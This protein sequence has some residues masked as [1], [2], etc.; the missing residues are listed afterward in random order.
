[1]RTLNTDRHEL[2]LKIYTVVVVAH[3][4]E[5]IAQAIQ[6]YVLDWPVQQARGILG[7]PFPGLVT[8]EWMHYG[9]AAIMLIGFLL[10]LPGFSG[11]SRVW[12]SAA[13]LLQIWHHFEH[14]I[15]LV[16]VMNGVNIGGGAAPTS[17]VQM[18]IPRVELHLFYNTVVFVPMVVAMYL[19]MR[20]DT[21]V[22]EAPWCSCADASGKG[23]G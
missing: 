15:L 3:W 18:L 4:A 1:M 14:L 16:Q 5:H 9:Y 12:W 21:A 2:S 22:R 6:I 19:H 13:L 7:I 23:R 10:L 11:R 20:Q 8:S 17:L